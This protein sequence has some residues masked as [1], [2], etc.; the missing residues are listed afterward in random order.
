MLPDFLGSLVFRAAVASRG[1]SH[2]RAL[3]RQWV[4]TERLPAGQFEQHVR[5]R[6]VGTIRHAFGTSPHYRALGLPMPDTGNVLDVLARVPPLTKDELR[7][8]GTRLLSERPGDRLI[9]KTTGGSTGQPLTITKNADAFAHELA[10][11]WAAYRS[12]GVHPGQRNFRFWGTPTS[13]QRRIRAI[14]ADTATNR[15][16]LSAFAFQD[17]DLERYWQECLR[18]RPR[19]LYGYASM[20]AEFASFLLSRG[21]DGARL[22]LAVVITTSEVL[23][24]QQRQLLQR[25]FGCAVRNEYGC[26]EVG[27]IAYECEA[28]N[29]HV[30][31]DN[32]YAE[33]IGPDGDPIV[34]DGS[35]Q[36]LVTD[37]HN[38]AM[39]LLRYAV[40]DSVER[41][42]ACTCGRRSPA[43]RRVWGREYDFV[44]MPDGRRY[45]GEYF[46]YL[47]ED[48]AARGVHVE[49]FQVVQEA[50][51][52][53]LIRLRRRDTEPAELATQVEEEARRRLP[54][55]AVVCVF[56][57]EMERRTSG[58]HSLII[59]R[60]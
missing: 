47:F 28:G 54:G 12:Y 24:D 3:E 49:Q 14:L 5:E 26:G 39:P 53:L 44:E 41:A 20:L 21:L 52:R 40:G 27:P 51:D 30:A 22:G 1:A 45:H 9:E 37:L 34:G 58:K 8:A 7:G 57:G 15:R 4:A 18:H 2:Y 36:L 33:V 46:L 42:G 56:V 35:G 23:S 59:R 50:R 17:A 19:F 25:A 13:R 31:A 16:T 60:T 29:L 38:R 43:L 11:T 32:I 6:L 10:A 48:L 55:V